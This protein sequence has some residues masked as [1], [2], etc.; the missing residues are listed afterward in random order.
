MQLNDKTFLIDNGALCSK[1]NFYSWI[2][3]TIL[4]ELIKT[5]GITTI[6]TLIL[7]KPNKKLTKIVQQFAQQTML[8]TILAT[9][10]YGCYYDLKEAFKNSSIKIIPIY[11]PRSK[12]LTLGIKNASHICPPLL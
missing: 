8:K 1:Q 6:D 12:N 11:Q 2:D 5:G 3:Y 10:K 4:P 9:T 7:Y